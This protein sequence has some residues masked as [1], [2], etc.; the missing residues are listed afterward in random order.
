MPTLNDQVEEIHLLLIDDE[1]YAAYLAAVRN[2]QAV[3]GSLFN[4]DVMAAG[5]I[6]D[7]ARLMGSAVGTQPLVTVLKCLRVVLRRYGLSRK[8]RRNRGESGVIAR[9]S[10]SAVRR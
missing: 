5:M 9:P 3:E 8:E 2:E 1:Q 10:Q 6:R 4:D 7:K